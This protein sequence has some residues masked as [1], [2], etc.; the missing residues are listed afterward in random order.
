MALIYAA[1]KTIKHGFPLAENGVESEWAFE[2]QT[3]LNRARAGDTVRLLKGQYHHP[4]TISAS[5]TSGKP[6]TIEGPI[7]GEAV[8]DGRQ[9]PE[10]GQNTGLKPEDG[11]FAFLKL[12]NVRRVILRRLTFKN[13]WPTSIYLRGAR[14]IAI[15]ECAFSEGRFAIYARQGRF[16]KTKRLLIEN[17]TW[18]QDPDHKMWTGAVTWE[19]VKL[20]DP[21]F[22]ASYFNGALFGSFDISG[23]VT[24]RHCTVSH[25]FNAIRMDARK[26]RVKE[27]KNDGPR[28]SRNRDVYIYGNRFS[29]VRDNAIE[30]ENAAEN[31]R[32]FGNQFFNIHACFS[33]DAVACRDMFYVGNT[34]LNNR[35]PEQGNTKY[36]GG[37]IFKYLSLKD[38][39]TVPLSSRKH[40]W[41]AFNSVQTR[42]SYAKKGRSAFWRDAYNAL[43]MYDADHPISQTK[44]RAAFNQLLWEAGDIQITGL[45]T[46]DPHHPDQYPAE[47]ID[48]K[49]IPRMA[50]V[51][52]LSEF[53]VMPDQELGGWDGRLPPSPT[54]AAQKTESLRMTRAGGK[55]FV[56]PAGLVPGACA[57]SELGL[58]WE[59]ALPLPRF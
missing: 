6:I 34:I 4:A 29:F 49:G 37:K 46:N 21:G 35:K 32:V 40:I 5:G 20:R 13:N 57:M 2:L 12:M 3:A 8:L 16:A 54:L 31:W 17:C 48:T 25:A 7:D 41:S 47:N 9:W 43:G 11:E 56:I 39:G 30:P 45:A 50:E 24:I 27:T 51:F 38:I 36:S 53:E 18:V 52:E 14:D 42:T 10:N 19:Q 44:P 1:P 58:T 26:S 22:D 59:D 33:L 55:D 28:V 15:S 23:G